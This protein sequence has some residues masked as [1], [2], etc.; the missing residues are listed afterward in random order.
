M[1]RAKPLAPHPGD[2][3]TRERVEALGLRVVSYTNFTVLRPS[4]GCW[5]PRDMLGTDG[6]SLIIY[7]YAD[8]DYAIDGWSTWHDGMFGGRYFSLGGALS[9]LERAIAVRAGREKDFRGC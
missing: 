4:G 3:F 1:K 5:V 7:H 8:K 6:K 9:W 2:G